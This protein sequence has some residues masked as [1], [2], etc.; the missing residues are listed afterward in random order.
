MMNLTRIV[1]HL[2]ALYYEMTH[3][4]E[5]GSH[6]YVMANYTAFTVWAIICIAVVGLIQTDMLTNLI[7]KLGEFF[8]RKGIQLKR[9]K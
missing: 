5:V 7:W 9:N 2:E 3:V 8:D 1:E 6:G 4:T